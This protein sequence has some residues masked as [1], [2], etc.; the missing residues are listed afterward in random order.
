MPSAGGGAA[1]A[2]SSTSRPLE[3]STSAALA[4]PSTRAHSS[5]DTTPSLSSSRSAW[6]VRTST[7]VRPRS[8]SLTACRR[9]ARETLP[10][11]SMSKEE[12]PSGM[13]SWLY[14]R[15]AATM[16]SA[17]SGPLPTEAPAVDTPAV[18]TPTVARA[19]CCSARARARAQSSGESPPAPAR[20]AAAWNPLIWS[21]AAPSCSRRALLTMSSREILPSESASNSAKEADC[22]TPWNCRAPTIIVATSL[23]WSRT[24]SSASM[25]TPRLCST[26]VAF[27]LSSTLTQSSWG[28]CPFF[29]LSIM[30]NH[31]PTSSSPATRSKAAADARRSA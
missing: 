20:S 7:S 16:S 29:S 30:L 28:M 12:K 10:S 19:P 8:R 4:R 31:C 6:R 15:Q 5:G 9:S 11:S 26:P 18:A 27:A 22:S 13:E 24:S 21:S 17:S 2:S 23:R 14:C 1:G 25:S 3:R